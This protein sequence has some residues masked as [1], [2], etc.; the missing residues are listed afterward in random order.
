M[1]MS[2]LSVAKKFNLVHYLQE[3]VVKLASFFVDSCTFKFLSMCF[4][5]NLYLDFIQFS[6]LQYLFPGMSLQPYNNYYMFEIDYY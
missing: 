2:G 4:R 3:T 1:L 5:H 6:S